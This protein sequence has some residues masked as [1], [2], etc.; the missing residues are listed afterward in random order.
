MIEVRMESKRGLEGGNLIWG[1]YGAI[2]GS[3]KEHV[4]TFT[5][6]LID[7]L[8]CLRGYKPF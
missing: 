4:E 5:V 1:A 8:L 3:E 2:S 6:F 7:L